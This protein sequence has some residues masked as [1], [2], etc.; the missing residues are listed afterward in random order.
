MENFKHRGLFN[1]R[2][3]WPLCEFHVCSGCLA[4]LKHATL[5]RPFLAGALFPEPGV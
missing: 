1:A 2:R 3:F 4:A 5:A